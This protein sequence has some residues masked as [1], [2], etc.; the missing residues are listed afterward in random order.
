MQRGSIT[1]VINGH[2][3]GQQSDSAMDAV[4]TE[5]RA[6]VRGILAREG[7][8]CAGPHGKQDLTMV[9]HECWLKL[10]RT[11]HWDNRAHFFGAASRATRQVLI[12]MARTRQRRPA[13]RSYNDGLESGL[14]DATTTRNIT[15]TAREIDAALNALGK[16]APRAARVGG[17]R[18]FGD[19]ST[20]MIAEIEGVTPRTVQRDW[21]FARAWLASRL[22]GAGD[23]ASSMTNMSDFDAEHA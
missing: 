3:Q 1:Q 17:Y 2:A 21:N 15:D 18:L 11:P 14:S 5:L 10:Q 20:E 16:H 9:V 19:L 6:C 4:Y 12:D 8:S 22:D 23:S 7:G 13:D